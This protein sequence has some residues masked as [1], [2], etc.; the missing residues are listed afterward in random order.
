M[1]DLELE[2]LQTP[3]TFGINLKSLP[4]L[5]L[6]TSEQPLSLGDLLN[7]NTLD[8]HDPFNS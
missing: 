2:L 8:L 3:D 1:S 5:S 6:L 7:H 4:R